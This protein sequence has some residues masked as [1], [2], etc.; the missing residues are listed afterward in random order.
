VTRPIVAFGSSANVS[1]NEQN[2]MKT[3]HVLNLNLLQ[4]V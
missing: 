3:L 2:S 4:T 1:N